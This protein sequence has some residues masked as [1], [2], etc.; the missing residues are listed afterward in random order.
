M[1]NPFSLSGK[2]IFVTGASSGI[3]KA[4]AIECSKMGAQLVISGRNENRLSETFRLLEGP[5]HL[6]IVADL[7]IEDNMGEIVKMLPLLDGIVHCAGISGHMPFP[8]I[9][10]QFLNE[11][12]DINFNVPTLLTQQLV[13]KKIIKNEGAILFITSISGI[14][15]S[16]AG[17]SIYS[18]TKGALSGLIKGMAIDLS[19]KK[20]RVNSI[21]PA[22]IKTSIMN[23]GKLTEE[24]WTEDEKKYPLK[25]YGQPEEVAYA[26]IYLLSDAAA[27]ITGTNLL[28]DGGRSISY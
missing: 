4:V 8:F 26:A 9:S 22:M 25:R 11:Q 10:K 2:T 13:K 16:Y 27:W 1:Y 24:Q 14:L 7:N 23:E 20:I 18:A 6:Q 17:G 21:M 5:G 28:I 19:P 3:G 12:F 15:S